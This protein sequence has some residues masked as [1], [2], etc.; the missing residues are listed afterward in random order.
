[1]TGNGLHHLFMVIYGMVYY[2]FAHITPKIDNETMGRMMINH[3]L[4]EYPVP[5]KPMSPARSN[6]QRESK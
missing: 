4:C 1:M 6:S 3:Q 5:D 2:C